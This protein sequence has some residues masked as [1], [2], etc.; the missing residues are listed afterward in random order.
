MLLSDACAANAAGD[1]AWMKVTI[2]MNSGAWSM[3]DA[4]LKTIS[5]LAHEMCGRAHACLCRR[6]T[7]LRKTNLRAWRRAKLV[8]KYID[9]PH[10][11]G[12]H[13]PNRC[14]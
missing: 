13:R 9:D 1:D 4:W 12:I 8:E 7:K 2:W 11:N 6:F 14:P 3:A 10:G 5:N